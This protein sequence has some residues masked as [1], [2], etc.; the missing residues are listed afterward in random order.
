[1]GEDRGAW[2]VGGRVSHLS[3]VVVNFNS[4][5]FLEATTSA[6]L[7]SLPP[8]SELIVV[9]NDSSDSSTA[10]LRDH[11]GIIFVQLEKN[12]GF[13]AAANIGAARAR[14]ELIV[15][16]NPDA[17]AGKIGRFCD[18]RI[19]I[20]KDEAVTKDAGGK[21]RNR[22]IGK[23]TAGAHDHVMGHRHFRDVE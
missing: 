17:F 22:D 1:M 4:G 13:G 10:S 11:D 20:D 16:L 9:D 18:T 5:A 19:F 21:H 14:N 2:V 23:F 7:A 6:L 8:G 15:F 12:V 3:V